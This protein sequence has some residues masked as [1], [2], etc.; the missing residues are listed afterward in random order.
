MALPIG[1]VHIVKHLPFFLAPSFVTYATLT[2]ASQLGYH[3]LPLGSVLGLSVLAI[4]VYLVASSL[5]DDRNKRA[6]ARRHGAVPPPNITDSV[7]GLRLGQEMR[8]SFEHGYPGD[9][10][11]KWSKNYGNAYTLTVLSDKRLFTT[12]PQHVKAILATQFDDFEKGPASEAQFSTFLGTGVFNSDGDRWKFHRSMTRPFFTKERIS[13]FDNFDRHAEDALHQAKIRLREGHPID[14][15][16]MISRFTLDSSAEFLFGQDVK[17]LAAGLNYPHTSPLSISSA[18]ADHPANIF[19]RSFVEGQNITAFRNFH[20][21]H[22]PAFEWTDAVKPHRDI[23]N[24]FIDP[25]IQKAIQRHSNKDVNTELKDDEGETLLDHLVNTTQDHQI[26]QDEILNIMLAGRDTTACTMTFGTYMLAEHPDILTK[27]RQEVLEKVGPQKRPDFDDLRDMKYMR[28]FI[29]ETLRLYPPVP[30]DGSCSY[31]VF[32]MHRRK[33]LWGP[34]AWN[35][36]PE[37]FL[38]DRVKLLTKNPFIFVPFNAGPRICLG[39]QFA[40]HEVSYFFIKLLQ[41]F[42][43]FSL[44]PEAQPP[45]T[46][47]PAEWKDCVGTKATEKVMAS[48]HLTMAVKGGL[49]IR[50]TEAEA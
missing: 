37:R 33:D 48:I 28:A 19:S 30:F 2:V 24:S 6:A 27:L 29:N 14:F 15:Q 36:D 40:Y 32:M 22:W 10:F 8:E 17:S 34:T 1:L 26:I 9:I 16:D 25:I 13:H 31:S 21:I 42:S 3:T 12:E 50:M 5:W 46:L 44:A 49:W 39:Q 18:N 35:F 45:S 38:D 20:G 47:P 23:V 11:E 41:K 43:G 4:P 7:G